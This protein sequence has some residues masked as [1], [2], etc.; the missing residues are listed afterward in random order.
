LKA[1]TFESVTFSK[2]KDCQILKALT[3]ETFEILKALNF[4]ND[5]KWR[6]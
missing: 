6:F 5:K 2:G 3:L 1:L 4:E